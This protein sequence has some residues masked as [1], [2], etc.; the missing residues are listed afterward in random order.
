[1]TVLVLSE[2]VD[3]TADAVVDVLNERGVAVFRCDTAWFPL[4]MTLDAEIGADGWDATLR[5]R[6]REVEF[7]GL[8]SIWYRS[9][10][11]FAFADGLS[12]PERRHAAMEAKLGLGGVLW[13]L[14]VL[15]VN[16]PGRQADLYKPVQLSVAQRCGL[17]VPR[18]LITN[19]PDAVRR[20]ALACDGDVVVKPLGAASI[21]EFGGRRPLY[22]HRLSAD[23]LSDMR[24]VEA[25]AHQFQQRLTKAYEVRL[26][27]VGEQ[28][29][30][31]TIHAGSDA[32][33]ADYPALKYG[34]ADVP[35]DVAAGVRAFMYRLG[36]VYGA[37]DF[38]VDG[39]GTWWFLECNPGGQFGWIEDA[40]GLP[41]TAALA[42]LLEKGE[43]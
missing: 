40:T 11:A 42:D 43:H 31:A 5:T 18:T 27:V 14:P 23:D 29:F 13:S 19:D 34:V 16:H 38:V 4:R 7:V 12:G 9:P 15:W 10:T 26:T 33:R 3:P 28:L 24:G 22:T 1:M 6:H 39:A 35:P 2:E 32:S 25:T 30:A 17:A 20:F 41:I 37:F 36:I 21:I 8:R